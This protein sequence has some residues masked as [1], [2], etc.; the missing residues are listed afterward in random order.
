MSD[1]TSLIETE[2]ILDTGSNYEED[3]LTENDE[4]EGSQLALRLKKDR[5]IISSVESFYS[6]Y[7]NNGKTTLPYM[8]KFEKAKLLGVRAEMIASGD[9]PMVDV[10]KNI[11]TAY[12]IALLE[13]EKNKIPLIIRRTLPNG[14]YEDW[15]IEEMIVK[16]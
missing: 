16:N 11:S 15:R 10:P 7:Y 6:N 12:E 3:T 13:L 9:A 4:E 5:D 8:S 1:T 14:K 2:S